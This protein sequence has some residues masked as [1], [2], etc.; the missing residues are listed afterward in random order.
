MYSCTNPKQPF[1]V[2]NNVTITADG[3]KILSRLYQPLIGHLGMSIY[4]TL[5]NEFNSLPLSIDYKVLYQLQEQLDCGLKDI[6]DS[7]H[8]LEAV[9]L[10]KTYLGDN[11]R[12]G[13]IIIFKLSE[14]TNAQ[15]FFS[16]FLLSSLLQEKVGIVAFDNLVKDF[17]PSL[18]QGLNDAKDVSSGF[19]DVFQLTGDH[20]IEPSQEVMDAKKVI[21][22]DSNSKVDIKMG[23]MIQ[24]IDWQFLED[25]LLKYHIPANEVDSHRTEIAQL[26]TFYQL[27]EQDFTKLATMCLHAGD[28][29]LDMKLIQ[30]MA[31]NQLGQQKLV[32]TVE[33]QLSETKS[34]DSLIPDFDNDE[35]KLLDDV[36]S[37][38][39]LDY[40]YKIKEKKGGYVTANEKRVVYRLENEYRL[41]SELINVLIKTCLDYTSVLTLNLADRIA[42]NWLQNKIH[43]AQEAIAYTKKWQK[44]RQVRR[45]NNNSTRKQAKTDWK[46]YD[47]DNGKNTDVSL[48]NEELNNIFNNFGRKE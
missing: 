27:G 20:A 15:E 3:Q 8:K 48:S 7:I 29:K 9:G 35:K 6:F 40:L 16:T 31:H 34:E 18:F 4:I 19:F 45:F 25:L 41:P 37:N 42:N 22:A 1:Y 24:K 32:H 23:K 12:L 17:T 43:T 2:A 11:P 30:R 36:N 5:A 38:Q 39:P 46:N 47:V 21:A 28:K 13:S 14:I 33:Q 44:N 10:I 26:M